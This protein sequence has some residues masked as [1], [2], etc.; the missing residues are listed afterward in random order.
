MKLRIYI[1]IKLFTNKIFTRIIY[2]YLLT[3]V[4]M[5]TYTRFRYRIIK[6]RSCLLYILDIVLFKIILQ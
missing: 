6:P 3:F 1:R 5:H 2:R 4:W